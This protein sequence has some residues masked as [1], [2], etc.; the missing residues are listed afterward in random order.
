MPGDDE[1]LLRRAYEAFN[2]RD[3]EAA[4]VLMHPDVDWPRR[5]A[6]ARAQVPQVMTACADFLD[7]P[8]PQDH[9]ASSRGISGG[10]G[11]PRRRRR[12]PGR[13]RTDGELLADTIVQHVHDQGRTGHAHGRQGL[14]SP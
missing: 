11:R 13:T 1:Q 2:A 9:R 6:K 12:P 14:T 10:P 5:D 8:V 7:A 4:I 3:I